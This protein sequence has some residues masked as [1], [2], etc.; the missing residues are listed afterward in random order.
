MKTMWQSHGKI[1][2]CIVLLLV[3]LTLYPRATYPQSPTDTSICVYKETRKNVPI[4]PK[5]NK[6][7]TPDERNQESFAKSSISK[8][9]IKQCLRAKVSIAN[10]HIVFEDYRDAWKELAKEMGKYD[11]PLWITGGVLH[12][13]TT[14]DMETHRGGIGLWEF[15][16]PTIK[17]A[18]QLT[19]EE[20]T[21]YGN[22]EKDGSIVFIRSNI[23]W[24]RVFM[25]VVVIS[26]RQMNS[27]AIFSNIASFDSTTFN[28]IASFNHS[29]L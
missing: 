15:G 27:S 3:P 5:T 19:E 4:N 28:N 1:I 29:K 10:H 23:R 2:T 18:S 6:P 24:I 17:D 22:T 14:Y 11:I 20:R 21:T 7:Y 16:D 12:A 9:E 8:E 26:A 25:N 13:K